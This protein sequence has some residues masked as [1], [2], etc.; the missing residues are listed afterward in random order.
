[1]DTSVSKLWADPTRREAAAS[2]VP[3]DCKAG[4]EK[5]SPGHRDK[6]YTATPIPLPAAFGMVFLFP[7]RPF[8]LFLWIHVSCMSQSRQSSL[9]WDHVLL[10]NQRL[11]GLKQAGDVETRRG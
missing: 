8:I 10:E 5:G 2:C 11:Q 3:A 4:W 1:M 7:T 6:T 9:C